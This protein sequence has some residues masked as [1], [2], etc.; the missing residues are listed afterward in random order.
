MMALAIAVRGPVDL[1]RQ[2]KAQRRVRDRESDRH[3]QPAL[4]F[5]VANRMLRDRHLHQRQHIDL[6][7]RVGGR[8]ALLEEQVD[9]PEP[10]RT[11]AES[12]AATVLALPRRYVDLDI[13]TV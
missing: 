12:R 5:A 3:E 1:W 13:R 8:Q 2:P 4:P 11:L 7:R 6:H 10:A 9:I